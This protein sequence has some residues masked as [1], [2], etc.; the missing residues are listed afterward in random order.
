MK[1]KK[2]HIYSKLDAKNKKNASK[3]LPETSRTLKRTKN[4]RAYKPGLIHPIERMCGCISPFYRMYKPGG[5][6]KPGLIRTILRYMSLRICRAQ[7]SARI[8]RV[9]ICE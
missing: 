5:V 7:M 6:Y 3:N 9:R 8:C 1:C 2:L 4:A